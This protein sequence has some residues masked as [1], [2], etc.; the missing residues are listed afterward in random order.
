MCT[1]NNR[2]NPFKFCE[3]KQ[4]RNG[5]KERNI[6]S[7]KW[8]M[9]T[10]SSLE[11]NRK[12]NFYSKCIHTLNS[13]YQFVKLVYELLNLLFYKIQNIW[14]KDN[15]NIKNWFPGKESTNL[16][17]TPN[18]FILFAVYTFHSIRNAINYISMVALR[19]KNGT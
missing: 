13:N 14:K 11:E 7:E 2:L 12:F 17:S 6:F 3:F 4:V 8:C 5:L 19:H 15:I 10:L 9:L 16:T 1:V 18:F